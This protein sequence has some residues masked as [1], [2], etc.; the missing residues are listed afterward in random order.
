MSNKKNRGA[1]MQAPTRTTPPAQP[2]G[3]AFGIDKD[4]DDDLYDGPDESTLDIKTF[5]LR[6]WMSGTA[7]TTR[8]VDVCGKPYLMGHIQELT[9][10]LERPVSPIIDERAG[11]M[12][13][14][15]QAEQ[16]IAE[17]IEAAREEMLGSIVTWK[18]TG[19]TPARI[20]ELKEKAPDV[21]GKVTEIDYR[22]WAAQVVSVNGQSIDL[23]WTDLRDLHLGTDTSSGLGEYFLQTIAATANAAHAGVGVTVPFSQRSSSLTRPQP[24]S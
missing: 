9:T 6:A 17:Q 2:N 12:S 4:L 15:Q 5:D 16:E 24:K 13:P 8:S 10:R 18:F 11:A 20:A 1:R 21:P 19:L 23:D 3:A 14:S 7:L 22:I